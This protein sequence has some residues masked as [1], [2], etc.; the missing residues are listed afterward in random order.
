MRQVKMVL[1]IWPILF[2]HSFKVSLYTK[3]VLA[4]RQETK[5]GKKM[6]KIFCADAYASQSSTGLT[7]NF[8]YLCEWKEWL[9]MGY[10][11]EKRY[12][13]RQYGRNIRPALQ[14]IFMR[15]ENFCEKLFRFTNHRKFYAMQYATGMQ[16]QGTG[17]NPSPWNTTGLSFH[18]LYEVQQ[19]NKMSRLH[20]LLYSTT[21]RP[22][23]CPC[24]LYGLL[25]S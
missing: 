7:S 2:F 22:Q 1:K 13:C 9:K 6:V 14:I 5:E 8:Q 18:F 16:W 12:Y 24:Q 4:E 20:V 11:G 23:L 21:V 19:I 17:I 10:M 3:F 25:S 15:Q